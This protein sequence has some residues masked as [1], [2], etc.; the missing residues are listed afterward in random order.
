VADV[1]PREGPSAETE[2]VGFVGAIS[3]VKDFASGDG[4]PNVT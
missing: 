3:R 2:Y 1:G 4:A